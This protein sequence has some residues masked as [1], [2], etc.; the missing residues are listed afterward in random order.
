MNWR[1]VIL[2]PQAGYRARW[3]N[4]ASWHRRLFAVGA[5]CLSCVTTAVIA[6]TQRTVIVGLGATTCA[7]F[8]ADV[9]KHPAVQ[10]DYLAWAQGFLSAILASRPQGVDEGLNLNPESFGLIKQLEFLRDYCGQNRSQ[11]FSDAV[12][13][14]YKRLRSEGDAS[15]K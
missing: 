12:E 13:A 4:A 6:K 11:S 9:S 2:L 8:L 14:L 1:R 15:R 7:Q 10:R 3:S 5:V